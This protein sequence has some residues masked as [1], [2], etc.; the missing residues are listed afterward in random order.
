[1][2]IYVS[3]LVIYGWEGERALERVKGRPRSFGR[4]VFFGTSSFTVEAKAF[5]LKSGKSKA[6]WGRPFFTEIPTLESFLVFL[7]RLSDAP[8]LR[9]SFLVPSRLNLST[10]RE[11]ETRP[12][13]GAANGGNERAGGRAL[14]LEVDQ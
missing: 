3:V 13:L 7:T 5:W 6:G 14:R 8:N 10:C 1:M 4:E 9:W 2:R 12:F 11:G